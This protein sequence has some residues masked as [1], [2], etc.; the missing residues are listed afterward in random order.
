MK[1]RVTPLGGDA[2]LSDQ[3]LELQETSPMENGHEEVTSEY[4]GS[5]ISSSVLPKSI[6]Q[7]P[8][9]GDASF[10]NRRKTVFGKILSKLSSI[11][12]ILP[13]FVIAQIVITVCRHNDN[14]SE[15]FFFKLLFPCVCA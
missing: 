2:P 10:M 15:I 3:T 9:Q 11:Q 13:I 6:A 7:N 14:F 4:S 8:F 1:H 12:I 5:T